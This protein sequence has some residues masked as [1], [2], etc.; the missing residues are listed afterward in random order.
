MYSP[1]L[2]K[3]LESYPLSGQQPK[4]KDKETTKDNTKETKNTKQK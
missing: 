2:K 4:D 3:V 1:D